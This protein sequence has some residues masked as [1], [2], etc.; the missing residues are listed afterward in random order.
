MKELNKLVRNLANEIK[1]ERRIHKGWIEWKNIHDELPEDSFMKKRSLFGKYQYI[2]SSSKG[3]ISLIK[4]NET[5]MGKSPLMRG[6]YWE[7]LCFKGNL[8]IDNER[9]KTK[10]QAE[11][12][13]KELLK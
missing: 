9:F 11:Q 1:I 6:D 3:E 2:Y 7:I 4:L 13:I 8:S 10:K 12:R 5:V